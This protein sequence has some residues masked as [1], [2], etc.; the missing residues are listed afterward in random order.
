[1]LLGQIKKFRVLIDLAT[2]NHEKPGHVASPRTSPVCR[3]EHLE[4]LVLEVFDVP[5]VLQLVH[6]GVEGKF[7]HMFHLDQLLID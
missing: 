4:A 7:E 5:P 3:L 2:T 1:M 6:V